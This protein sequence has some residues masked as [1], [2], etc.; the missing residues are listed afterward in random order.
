[1]FDTD[2][3]QDI[4]AA[5]CLRLLA[6]VGLGRVVLTERAMP[7]VQVVNFAM[8]HGDVVIRTAVGGKLAAAASNAVVAFEVDQFAAD[9]R[10]GWSVVVVGHASEVR[11]EAE[12]RALRDLGVRSWA[13][14][15]NEHF[16]RIRPE[17]VSGRRLPARS[18]C[19]GLPA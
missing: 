2:G 17:I 7:T 10:A 19:G 13:P 14:L 16:I 15:E 1:V 12:L 5:E 4:E 3:L 11:D 9:L 18:V 8:Y 6:G